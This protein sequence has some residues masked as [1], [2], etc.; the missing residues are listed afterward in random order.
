M[1]KKSVRKPIQFKEQDISIKG[2]DKKRIVTYLK[3]QFKKH[4]T[5]GN[6]EKA[7]KYNDYS[8]KQYQLDLRNWYETKEQNKLSNKNVFG[9]S[10]Q[11]KLRYG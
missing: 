5:T 7:N 1:F 6:L 9:F 2:T 8:L 10:K 11:R 3:S 4:Y